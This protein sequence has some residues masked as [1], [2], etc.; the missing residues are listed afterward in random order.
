MRTL[1]Q[2]RSLVKLARAVVSLKIFSPIPETV[3]EVEKKGYAIEKFLFQ[4][5]Q[6]YLFRSSVMNKRIASAIVI[7]SMVAL[8]GGCVEE[9]QPQKPAPQFGVVNLAQ[10]YQES[11]IG[12][13]GTARLSELEVLAM[14]QLEG[15][16]GQ[17]EKA[18]ADQNEAEA[19]R[20]EQELQSQVYFM[21]N[22]IKQ[23]QE[24]VMNVLQ[25]EMR[26]AFDSYSE[27]N[28]LYGLFSADTML[29]SSAV[30]DVTDAVRGVLDG[31]QFSFGDL[32]SLEMPRLPEPAN[33]APREEI[34]GVIPP[35][36]APEV[37]EVPAPSAPV[38]AP[39]M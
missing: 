36:S 18:R 21:Q 20:L 12:Q 22:A 35:I 10:L 34:P 23:D 15:V 14:K 13:M 33:A 11:K 17:L 3:A 16:Q 26:K 1:D 30:I 38:E 29:S 28:G 19:A 24:H 6:T 37:E 31:A 39:V 4:E 7:A 8:L 25:T 32:P 5:V 9:K 2:V 27:A